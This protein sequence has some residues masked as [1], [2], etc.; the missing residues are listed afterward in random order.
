VTGDDDLLAL[1]LPDVSIVSPRA[2]FELLP[3]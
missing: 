2:F 3:S 1:D